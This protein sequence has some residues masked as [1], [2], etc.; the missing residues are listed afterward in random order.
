MAH[1]LAVA[2]MFPG[3]CPDVEQLAA[4]PA[5]EARAACRGMGPELFFPESGDSL[6]P[7]RDVC[8]RCEVRPECL[9]YALRLSTGHLLPGI[10]A[11]TSER[12]RR[13]LRRCPEVPAVAS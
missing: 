10:W 11:G 8:A 7:G 13:Q 4:R 5:W 6:E 2:L 9:E 12:G 3:E 1:E